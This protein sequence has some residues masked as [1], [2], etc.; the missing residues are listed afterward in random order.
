MEGLGTKIGRPRS[1]KFPCKPTQVQEIF[2]MRTSNRAFFNF[3][4]NPKKNNCLVKK[5]FSFKNKI[6]NKIVEEIVS[7][8][9][10][11]TPDVSEISE[12]PDCSD[13]LSQR[14]VDS[15]LSFNAGQ[16]NDYIYY[17]NKD[18]IKGIVQKNFN[19]DFLLNKNENEEK[20]FR[21][22]ALQEREI[23]LNKTE[24]HSISSN[25]TGGGNTDR[26]SE[27]EKT[28]KRRKKIQ[29][30]PKEIIKHLSGFLYG[31][32]G[33]TK[34][35]PDPMTRNETKLLIPNTMTER[36]EIDFNEK[37][38]KKRILRRARLQH[39]NM[40]LPPSD[41]YISDEN[42]SLE[43]VKTLGL[44]RTPY[45]RVP[46]IRTQQKKKKDRLR[47]R[48]L[49]KDRLDR[50]T[51]LL[52]DRSIWKTSKKTESKS[53]SVKSNV[54]RPKNNKKVSVEE[55]SPLKEK[56]V[57]LIDEKFQK[58][59]MNYENSIEKNVPEAKPIT[60]EEFKE[61]ELR[62]KNLR[63]KTASPILDS[64][65]EVLKKLQKSPEKLFNRKKN[66]KL[67]RNEEFLGP[68]YIDPYFM[69]KL[70]NPGAKT[71]KK[72]YTS[73]IRE[74]PGLRERL[75]VNVPKF[76]EEKLGD[77]SDKYQHRLATEWDQYYI[78]ELKNKTQTRKFCVKR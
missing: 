49:K 11:E 57:K 53:S 9:N 28:V 63:T 42:D 61:Q 8:D 62:T 46:T 20:S 22:W 19:E 70:R 43:D 47:N 68:Y 59:R 32:F 5:K 3:T 77:G 21:E 35:T 14:T 26:R 37:K 13:V 56:Y 7:A 65:D 12:K 38:I 4:E 36:A 67:Y 41:D 27:R 18:Q 39:M 2:N 55:K 74:R 34:V 33:K 73:L 29:I 60:F 10:H 58:H 64:P 31:P 78:H 1:K 40:P 24:G 66:Q 48:F 69:D 16:Q 17:Y 15:S 50:I 30:K 71:P 52:Y 6:F 25:C 76:N 72:Y 51:M 54:V 45:F 23:F 75:Q 44:I